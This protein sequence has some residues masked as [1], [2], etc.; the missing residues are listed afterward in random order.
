MGKI[1][2]CVKGDDDEPDEVTIPSEK[3]MKEL[4]REIVRSKMRKQNRMKNLMTSIPIK[5]FFTR[6][7]NRSEFK[8]NLCCF[9]ELLFIQLILSF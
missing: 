2:A 7:S 9:K 1:I 5:R 8:G 6:K 4:F 3:V